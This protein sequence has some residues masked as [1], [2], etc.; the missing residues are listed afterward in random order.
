MMENTMITLL[1]FNP[2]LPGMEG[3]ILD[4]VAVNR[5]CRYIQTKNHYEFRSSVSS[6]LSGETIVIYTVSDEADL[7]FLESIQDFLMDTK[8]FINLI[9][10]N[11]DFMTRILK[12]SP[13]LFTNI[14]SD[15]K[16]H[17]LP[18]AIDNVVREMMKQKKWN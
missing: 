10:Q 6:C 16:T 9:K 13:R 3:E 15:D 14:E 18:E 17:L 7:Q 11:E 2:N 8:L 1:L 4:K 5:E 12:L